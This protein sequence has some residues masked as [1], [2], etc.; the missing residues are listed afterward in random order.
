MK[1]VR[2]EPGPQG[3]KVEW[4]EVATPVAKAGQVLVR[5]RAAGVNRGDINRVRE[6]RSGAA[7]T[8]G[9]EF[10]GEI[11]AVG[12]QVT[13]W[14]EGERVMGHARGSQA[15]YVL[16]D[17][18]AMMRVPDGLSWAEAAAFPN[19]FITA[20]DAVVTNGKVRAGESVL[21]NGASG[22][23]AVAARGVS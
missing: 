8:A 11:A 6:A 16:C 2:V 12:P 13:G 21:I 22:G 19:V 9:I 15:E 20:H 23:V 7:F 14:S 1:A 4:Q 17:P 3:G 5:V 10:A 18:L